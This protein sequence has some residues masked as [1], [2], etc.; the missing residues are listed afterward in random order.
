MTGAKKLTTTEIAVLGLIAWRELSGYELTRSIDNSVRYFWSPARSRVY[1]IL[2]RL[3]ESGLASARTSPGV[4]GPEKTLYRATRA[5]EAALR[6]WLNDPTEPEASRSPFLLK[7]FFGEHATPDR[8]RELI[9][10][11][12]RDS[13]QLLDY[14]RVV[15][16]RVGE[17]DPYALL[18]IR[19][20]I[21]R[22]EAT[23]RWADDAR[24]TV[25]ALRGGD[26]I[27][28]VPE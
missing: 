18:T 15:E 4:R 6:K 19:Y 5:G 13:E 9:D 20:G 21:H 2:P 8:L 14:L 22:A 3:L 23:L 12:A 24:A 16:Q 26:A 27:R 10:E 25:A 28:R 7:L 11:Y 17:S 1:E